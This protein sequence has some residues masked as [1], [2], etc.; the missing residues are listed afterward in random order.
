MHKICTEEDY[1]VQIPLILG[2]QGD[3]G[4]QDDQGD[5]GDN[6]DHF[7]WCEQDNQ[8]QVSEMLEVSFLV[9]F[10]QQDFKNVAYVGCIRYFVCVFVIVFVI[11]F[12]FVFVSSYDF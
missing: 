7:G 10:S 6:S 3:L 11:V 2:D 1:T 4:D 9:Y 8:G 5:H 12:V